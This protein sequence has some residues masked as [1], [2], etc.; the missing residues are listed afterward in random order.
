MYSFF[1]TL[2]KNRFTNW[3][4]SKSFMRV[5]RFSEK[6]LENLIEGVDSMEQMCYNWH[7]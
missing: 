7:S 2:M 3:I 5:N 1:A 6:S 4:I